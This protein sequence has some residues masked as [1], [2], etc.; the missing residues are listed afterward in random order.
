MFVGVTQNIFQGKYQLPIW[1]YKDGNS[2]LFLTS[3]F[4]MT[5]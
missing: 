5:K 2:L 3:L 4:I 1:T